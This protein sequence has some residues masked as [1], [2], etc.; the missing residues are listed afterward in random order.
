MTRRCWSWALVGCSVAARAAALAQP[1][2]AHP[3]FMLGVVVRL[4][5]NGPVLV[6]GAGGEGC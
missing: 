4:D 3:P 6:I 1:Q 2:P 5:A